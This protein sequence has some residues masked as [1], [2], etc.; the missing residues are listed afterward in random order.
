MQQPCACC[1]ACSR[2]VAHQQL[3]HPSSMQPQPCPTS[4]RRRAHHGHDPLRPAA[5]AQLC[6]DVSVHLDVDCACLWVWASVCA[7][8]CACVWCLSP[9]DLQ[10]VRESMVLYQSQA[11]VGE[12]VL[13]S[14]SLVPTCISHALLR[15]NSQ[16]VLTHFLQKSLQPN[17]LT[18]T[19]PPP[20]SPLFFKAHMLDASLVNI[21]GEGRRRAAAWCALCLK[22]CRRGVPASA[23]PAH[24]RLLIRVHPR[25]PTRSAAGRRVRRHR[26]D[27]EVERQARDRV[28]PHG[29]LPGVARL[30]DRAQRRAAARELHREFCFTWLEIKPVQL[31]FTRVSGRYR[32][33]GQVSGLCCM[34]RARVD[35][36][37]AQAAPAYLIH[38]QQ[39]LNNKQHYQM[40]GDAA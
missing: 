33:A 5:G 23:R 25:P 1:T 37:I 12:T 4:H 9:A 28:A 7:S 19:P 10:V 38:S 39:S 29:P 22:L 18:H 40:A 31:N 26:Q 24:W 32:R 15:V 21:A 2:G 3:P 17:M 8:V 14:R 34:K 6:L 30:C 16:H 11:A 36:Q 13:S 35:K 20:P 27:G